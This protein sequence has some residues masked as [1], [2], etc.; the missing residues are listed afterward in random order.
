VLYEMAKHGADAVLLLQP[1]SPLLNAEDLWRLLIP[2]GDSVIS[3]LWGPL[4]SSP[5]GAYFATRDFL[6]HNRSFNVH[7]RTGLVYVPAERAIDIDTRED[8]EKA[9]RQALDW[10]G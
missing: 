4:G 1:T 2:K 6:D 3:A 5:V 7:G 9:E 10:D 8:F